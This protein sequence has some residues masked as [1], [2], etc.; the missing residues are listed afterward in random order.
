MDI[1]NKSSYHELPWWQMPTEEPEWGPLNPGGCEV[2][3]LETRRTPGPE[4]YWAIR[5]ART[6]RLA[7]HNHRSPGIRVPF[8]HMA[9]LL[10]FRDDIVDVV[11]QLPPG[12]ALV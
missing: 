5:Y 12:Y 10:D 1:K 7:I 6:P 8:D 3:L 4:T 2:T 11:L 9:V